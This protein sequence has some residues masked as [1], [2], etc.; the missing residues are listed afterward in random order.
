MQHHRPVEWALL[1]I[2]QGSER[3]TIYRHHYWK[4]ATTAV[5]GI[6]ER[7]RRGKPDRSIGPRMAADKMHMART[8]GVHVP[9]DDE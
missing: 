1:N 6:Q 2:G 5:T 3:S 7:V 9:D 8:D 4:C